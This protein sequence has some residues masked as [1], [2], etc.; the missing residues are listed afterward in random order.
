MRKTWI[1]PYQVI[2]KRSKE[3]YRVRRRGEDN[4]KIVHVDKM[5][6]YLER[7]LPEETYAEPPP[8]PVREEV[9][10]QPE[11][12]RRIEIREEEP[13]VWEVEKVL[14]HRPDKHRNI[15]YEVKWKGYLLS[16]NTW[17]PEENMRGAE[18]AIKEYY[19]SIGGDREELRARLKAL[20]RRISRDKRLG[21]TKMKWL[22]RDLVGKTSP[23]GLENITK[24]RMQKEVAEATSYT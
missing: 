21:L 8:Q 17:K 22:L 3:V 1:G 24:E 12:E 18:E 20:K 2:E 4:L 23:F 9:P 11:A 19:G 16:E 7:L 10:P 14:K 13:N 15:V 6:P 5:K